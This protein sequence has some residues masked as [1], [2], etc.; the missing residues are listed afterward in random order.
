MNEEAH[1][2]FDL[3]N[4]NA[5]D[6]E[7]WRSKIKA[8]TKAIDDL[9]YKNEVEGIEFD[10]TQKTLEYDFGVQEVSEP[11]DW[12]ISAYIPVLDEKIANSFALKCLSQGANVLYF[13]ISSKSTDWSA[14]F[15]DIHIEYIHIIVAFEQE[16]ELQNFID[17][18]PEGLIKNVSVSID[19]LRPHNIKPILQAGLKLMVNG[20]HLEQI[21][22]N[23]TDQMSAILY[24]AESVIDHIDPNNI[25]FEIG[26]G[27]NFFVEIAKVRTLKWLWQHIL[28]KNKK[29]LT[30][31]NILGRMGW[32]NKSLSDPDTNILRQTTES[33]SAISGGVSSILIHSSHTY[34]LETYNWFYKRLAIN[35]SHILKEESYLTK[36]NDPTRGAYLS[37]KMTFVMIQNCWS[38]FLMLIDIEDDEAIIGKLKDSIEKTRK[39]KL[40]AYRKTEHELIG[41]NLFKN[42]KEQKNTWSNIPNYLDFDYLIFEMEQDA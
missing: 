28:I 29:S 36:V 33:I 35:I 40:E 11:N 5:P 30:K 21:G 25:S 20:F 22:A 41:I 1:M 3:D 4:F 8:E 13:N 15:K 2:K 19:P 37:E 16:L 34:S 18:I 42:N 17:F 39:I 27:S 9:S 23:A 7:A 26:I 12:G 32:T 31:T 10:P 6:L 38:H 24:Y 14:I